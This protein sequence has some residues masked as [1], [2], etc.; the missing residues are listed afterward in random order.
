MIDFEKRGAAHNVRIKKYVANVRKMFR[1]ANSDLVRLSSQY[2]M[3][4]VFKFANNPAMNL[5]ADS[6]LNQLTEDITSEIQR[7]EEEESKAAND[8][9]N[10]MLIDMPE[11]IRNTYTSGVL[12]VSFTPELIRDYVA[13]YKSTVELGITEGQGLPESRIVNRLDYALTRPLPMYK[14]TENEIRTS[15]IIGISIGAYVLAER[16]GLFNPGM[17]YNRNPYKDIVRLVGDEINI[18]Y[19]TVIEERISQIPMVVGYEIIPMRDLVTCPICL[20]LA[21]IYPIGFNWSGWHPRCRCIIKPVLMTNEEI[22]E[23]ADRLANGEPP[24]DR[25]ESRN[26][27]AAPGKNFNQFLSVNRERLSKAYRKGTAYRWIYN[28]PNYVDYSIF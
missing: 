3:Q 5:R 18:S 10:G 28:N 19:R 15:D 20:D 4:G 2:P 16:S 7:A 11:P 6:I 21:G 1:R 8:T 12:A 17:G 22:Q 27:V 13:K 14:R 23:S 24:L 26:Y 9:I 25:N